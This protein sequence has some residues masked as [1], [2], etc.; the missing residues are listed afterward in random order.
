[1]RDNVEYEFT[2]MFEVGMDHN[3]TTSKDRTG[4]FVDKTFPI[5]ERT[6]E[7]IAGW[8]NGVNL[9]MPCSDTDTFLRQIADA[10]SKEVLGKIGLK[11]KESALPEAQRETIR[12]AYRERLSA[13]A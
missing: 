4:L 11:I 6:G 13:L 5:T 7:L 10:D 1:M 12:N 3:A 2:T 8:L 9:V